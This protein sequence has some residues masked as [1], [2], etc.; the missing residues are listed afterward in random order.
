MS[1]P[2]IFI[3]GKLPPPW[4]GPAIAT[5]IILKSSL[6]NHFN[7]IH[8]DTGLNANLQ[9][10]GKLAWWK[11]F[12]GLWLYIGYFFKLIIYRPK[13][14][15][16]PNGQTTGAF[17]KDSVFIILGRLLGRKILL[18]LRGSDWENWLSKVTPLTRKYVN[19]NLRLSSGVIV[20]GHNLKYLFRQ[21]FSDDRIF[22]VSNGANYKFPEKPQKPSDI[23][24][25]LFFSNLFPTKGVED[26]LEASRILKAK[27]I[28]GIKYRMVGAW[29][30][31]SFA[32]K[33]NQFVLEH[34]LPVEFFQPASG[35]TKIKFF[36]TSDILVFPP[37][38]PEGHPWVVVEG[39]AAGLPIISTDQGAIIES[40]LNG[41]NGFIVNTNSPVQIAE[42]IELLFNNPELRV[43]MGAESRKHY[44]QNF[45]ED[46]MVQNLSFALNSVISKKR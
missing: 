6:N 37:R 43:K 35:E 42:K 29:K 23:F 16:I 36:I 33:C 20:L 40:V 31:D 5:D 17:I 32:Q 28:D 13:V 4:Y 30:S 2:R 19:F 46:K 44:E 12:K 15:L 8:I 22:V 1:K 34:Q 27:G 14:V 11:P 7:I 41:E 39:L 25:V 24:E 3:L 18:Q 9:S 10:M 21:N 38:I 26:V 45:T